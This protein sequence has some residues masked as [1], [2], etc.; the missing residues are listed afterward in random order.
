MQEQTPEAE[1]HERL[2]QSHQH[3]LR[4]YILVICPN[5]SAME[6]ILQETNRVLWQK[7]E[8][9]QAGTNFIAWARTVAQF[10]T[11]SYLKKRKSKSWL[12]F[13]SDLVRT[14]A[15]AHIQREEDQR[16]K[17]ASRLSDCLGKLSQADRELVAMRYE[18]QMSLR[19]VSETTGRTE[20]ALKQTF[21]RIRKLLRECIERKKMEDE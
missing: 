21:M 3:Q 15:D 2:I 12:C 8:E 9:F 20:G 14:L 5:H 11:M 13:D 18:R 17:S 7:R 16:S 6:D 19:E 4:G 10:Q 1:Q